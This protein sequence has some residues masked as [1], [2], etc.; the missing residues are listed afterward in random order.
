MKENELR[1]REQAENEE[2]QKKA[3]LL[4]A[5]ALAKE[6]AIVVPKPLGDTITSDE[7]SV[8][9]SEAK[10]FEQSIKDVPGE[11]KKVLMTTDGAVQP[12]GKKQ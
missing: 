9:L 6:A 12:L 3:A 4:A 1:L 5:Q 2:R 7:Q 11:V 8:R 10:A